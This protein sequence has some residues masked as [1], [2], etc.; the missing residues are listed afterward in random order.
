MSGSGRPRDAQRVSVPWAI[1]SAIMIIF[2]WGNSTVPGT[3]S[4]AL[5]QSVVAAVRAA[6][7]GVGLPSA[8]VTNFLV[9]KCGHFLEYAV[10]G[11]LVSQALEPG[12]GSFRRSLPAIVFILVLVPC[13][14]ESIQLFIPGRSGQV[15]DVLLDVCGAAAG[16][17]L[18]TVVV[19]R[20]KRRRAVP[21]G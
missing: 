12:R 13:I 14:D 2:I 20:K 4:S 18:R 11:V 1:A 17:V 3:G 7:E 10:L 16:V 8:W 9:R 15:T 6:L 21:K 19:R 5:S